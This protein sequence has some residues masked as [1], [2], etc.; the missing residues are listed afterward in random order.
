MK[1]LLIYYLCN[2]NTFGNAYHSKG[3][4]VAKRLQSDSRLTTTKF[5]NGVEN[6]LSPILLFPGLGASKLLQNNETVYPPNFQQYFCNY[7]EWKHNIILNKNLKTL[8]FGDKKSFELNVVSSLIKINRYE[9]LLR[10]L[11]CIY[12][13]PYDFRLIDNREY[14]HNLYNNIRLYIE[15][16]NCPVTLLCHS[17]GGLLM[18]WFIHQQK[19]NWC[20]KHIKNIINI[21]VPF[22]GI[23]FV[24]ENCIN[25]KT[26][27]NKLLGKEIFCS[28]GATVW[29]MPDVRFLQDPVIKVD[30]K[31]IRDYLDFFELHDIQSRVLQNKD[32]IDSFKIGTNVKTY[33]IYSTTEPLNKTPITLNINTKYKHKHIISTTYG[34][35]DGIVPL[36]SLL[37]PK[38]WDMSDDNLFF[39]HIP[40]SEHSS[41]LF[42]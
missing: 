25:D 23:P 12:P 35:G 1:K 11:D 22:G 3:W 27:L 10:N 17:T 13:M 4:N 36:E 14:L 41:I 26:N 24:L 30:G 15:H 42:R 34:N 21:N 20:N 28:L 33:I 8:P 6:S 31:I 19:Q 39:H 2:I 40:N 9:N 32:I 16:F 37:I 5:R 7:D 38:L 29:N 18:H